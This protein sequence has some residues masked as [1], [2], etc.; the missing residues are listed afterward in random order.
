MRAQQGLEFR[1][2]LQ[3]WD[4]WLLSQARAGIAD[5]HVE[6]S[7]QPGAGESTETHS[8]ERGWVLLVE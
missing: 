2:H 5:P 7:P 8:A 1:I 6:V 4:T 3:P